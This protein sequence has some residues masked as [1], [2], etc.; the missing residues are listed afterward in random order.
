MKAL[1]IGVP[2]ACVAGIGMA[3]FAAFTAFAPLGAVDEA[4]ASGIIIFPKQDRLVEASPFGEY[5]TVERVNSDSR[6]STLV[7]IAADAVAL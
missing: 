6:E 3:M 7:R 1:N 2:A 4:A 5:I